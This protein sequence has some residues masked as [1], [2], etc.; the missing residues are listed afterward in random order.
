MMARRDVRVSGGHS[1]PHTSASGFR[2]H[3]T[4]DL[5]LEEA[6]SSWPVSNFYRTLY[7]GRSLLRMY[8]RDV[9]SS[10]FN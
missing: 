10:R 6:P 5:L 9:V 2:E 3:D 1:V 7:R 4:R 8:R